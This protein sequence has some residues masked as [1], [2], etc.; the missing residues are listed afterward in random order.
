MTASLTK[1]MTVYVATN[2]VQGGR[3][4]SDDEVTVSE[5]AWHTERSRMFF[6]PQSKVAIHDLL[7]EIVID[8]GNDASVA[9]AEHIAGDQNSLARLERHSEA[10]GASRQA[11]QEPYRSS[12]AGTLF[13]SARYGEARTDDHQR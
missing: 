3:L 10:A 4:R 5:N 9:L 13:F 12:C 6:D 8:S 2:E 7:R 11:L 1:L